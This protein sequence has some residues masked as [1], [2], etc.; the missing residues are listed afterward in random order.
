MFKYYYHLIFNSISSRKLLYLSMVTPLIVA[1]FFMGVLVLYQYPLF[2]E[3]PRMLWLTIFYI[4]LG[5]LILF[6]VHQRIF[7]MI[8]NREF[9]LKKLMGASIWQVGS[10]LMIESMVNSLVG[11]FIGLTLADLTSRL[12]NLYTKDLFFMSNLV[13]VKAFLL[14]I[15]LLIV[16][17]LSSTIFSL[18]TIYR[19]KSTMTEKPSVRKDKLVY[20][21]LVL[22]VTFFVS[23]SMTAFLPIEVVLSRLFDPSISFNQYLLLLF[24]FAGASTIVYGL[25]G[26]VL[27]VTYIQISRSRKYRLQMKRNKSFGIILLSLGLEYLAL[28]APGAIIGY[29]SINYYAEVLDISP[30]LVFRVLYRDNIILFLIYLLPFTVNPAELI[31]LRKSVSKEKISG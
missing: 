9:N 18:F 13:T 16:T 29:F 28:L 2:Q 3:R 24:P 1:S 15:I 23:I 7:W 22:L 19:K 21:L 31:R 26:L 5:G 30:E 11:F 27:M 14:L 20:W 10:Q 4:Y 8:R 12:L 17:S 6:M 25:G